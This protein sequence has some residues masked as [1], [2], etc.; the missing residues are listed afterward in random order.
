MRR[1]RQIGISYCTYY[2]TTELIN[3]IHPTSWVKVKLQVGTQTSNS[4]NPI[5]LSLPVRSCIVWFLCAIVYKISSVM[6]YKSVFCNLP[7]FI[8]MQLLA[9]HGWSSAHRG[10]LAWLPDRD[11]PDAAVL[12]DRQLANFKDF[13]LRQ[14]RAKGHSGTFSQGSSQ[15]LLVCASQL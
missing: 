10:R 11:R 9:D 6:D 1:K 14:N 12:Q 7:R 3:L 4:L 2:C 8:W 5:L 13:L 15:E